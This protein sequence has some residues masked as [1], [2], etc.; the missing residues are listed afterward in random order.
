MKAKLL[1]EAHGADPKATLMWR[2]EVLPEHNVKGNEN[3]RRG[4]T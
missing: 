2:M 1:G 3:A 4:G